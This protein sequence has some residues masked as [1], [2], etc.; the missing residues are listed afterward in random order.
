MSKQV[1][2]S[3]K[4]TSPI[5]NSAKQSA[6]TILARK[7]EIQNA[8]RELAIAEAQYATCVAE[9]KAALAAEKVNYSAELFELP[10]AI[11]SLKRDNFK[12]YIQ[13]SGAYITTVDEVAQ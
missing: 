1:E 9:L 11:V 3:L 4:A 12:S 6:T 8:Q 5:F 2:A 13:N 10:A 7:A